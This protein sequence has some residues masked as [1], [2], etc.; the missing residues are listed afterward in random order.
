MK[1]MT[2]VIWA[3]WA[4]FVVAV[5]IAAYLGFNP[6]SGAPITIMDA[7]WASSFIGFPTAGALIA[8][9][10]PR[11]PL[12]WILLVA[13][14]LLMLGLDLS[15]G[16]RHLA[17][18]E[19][20]ARWVLWTATVFLSAGFG[21]LLTILL[22]LPDGYL[23][24]PRWSWVARA[25]WTVPPVALLHTALKPGPLEAGADAGVTNPLAIHA[26]QPLFDAIEVVLPFL[27][28][29]IIGAGLLS[30]IGRSRRA[31]GIERQQLK[32]LALGAAGILICFG[33]IAVFETFVRDL[34]DAEVTGVIVLAILSLPTSIAVA[35]LKTRLY[36]V[37]V[38][39]NRTLVYGIL[40]AILASSYFAIVVL[41][42]RL[43]EPVTRQSDLAVAGSTLA[44]AAA[45]R[46]LLRRVQDFVD[47]RFYRR[48]YDAAATLEAFSARLR[49]QVD[50]SSLSRE[51]VDVVGATMQPA[52][53]SL[54]L[55]S[56]GT[57]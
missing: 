2:T 16:S 9:R 10:L 34:A 57:R 19:S 27:F 44:V 11:R 32:W 13:P 24:S 8:R 39:I 53:A 23:P 42:Q 17:D 41:L 47:R 6:P 28:F 18:D 54:W 55:R 14:L 50:L 56:G 3:L 15:E 21:S 1:R 48:K 37:D 35:V 12:G 7:I 20:L 52:H 26:L 46:P 22:Y 31:R 5:S 49:D 29:G 33:S 43:L 25:V 45:A 30:L 4:A 36:D 51:L 38:I 40:T